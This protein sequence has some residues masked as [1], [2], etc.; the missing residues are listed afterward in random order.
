[1]ARTP[2]L[3]PA[4]RSAGVRP[5]A[6][7][8]PGPAGAGISPGAPELDP[9]RNGLLEQI[10]RIVSR[11]PLLI[12]QAII[13]VAV[14]AYAYSATREE[15]FTATAAISF[16][17][18]TAGLDGTAGGFVDPSRQAATREQLLELGVVAERTAQRLG[19]RISAPAVTEA[20]DTVSTPEADIIQLESTTNDPQLSADVANTYAD[21]FVDFRRDSARRQYAQAINQAEQALNALPPADAAGD[22]G[23]RLRDR[24]DRLENL[25][26]LQTGDAELV[27]RARAPQEASAPR[28]VRNGVLGAVLGALLGFGLAALRERVDRAIKDVDEI[29]RAYGKPVLARIPRSREL[30]RAQDLTLRGEEAE[31]FRMMRSNLRYFGVR[32]ELRSLLVTSALP[33]EG[34]STVA[35][36]L[37][38]TM[39]TMG[40]RVVLVMADLHNPQPLRELD[41]GALRDSVGLS[42]VLV[43]QPLSDALEEVAL[44]AGAEQRTLTVLPPGPLP[45]N[46]SELLESPRMHE[47]LEDLQGRYDVVVI[48]SPPAAVLSDTLALVSQVSGV[49]VVS[50]VGRTTLEAIRDCVRSIGLLGGNMLGV[51]ANFAPASDRSA[52]SYYTQRAR[53]R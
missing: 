41:A 23:E 39:A 50:A 31:A 38:E 20:V 18:V 27:Q 47:V 24:V 51:I 35:R 29:E 42:G 9:N 8:L 21:A 4:T 15:Q 46:P 44:P 7:S 5:A 19:D 2:R 14:A 17:D 52:S 1:M 26:A 25:Q 12:L 13:I 34:K 28:P 53:A 36:Y 10:G 32:Q 49:I 43:G 45:P 33:E 11:H 40:D 48:D 3:V 30:A 16:E 6:P 22:Q 37:A